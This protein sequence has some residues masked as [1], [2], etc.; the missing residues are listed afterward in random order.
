MK[1]VNILNR[2][3]FSDIKEIT[4]S[5]KRWFQKSYGNTYHSVAVGSLING[6]WIDLAVNTFE[7]GY[8]DHYT[9]TAIRLLK[10]CIKDLDIDISGKGFYTITKLCNHHGINLSDNVMDVKR[11]KDL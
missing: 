5:A 8:G 10:E 7:Y 3:N 4:I 11:K 9:T 1:N 6:K 2:V